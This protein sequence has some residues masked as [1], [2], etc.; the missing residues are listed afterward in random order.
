MANRSSQGFFRRPP[1]VP[2]LLVVASAGV[3]LVIWTIPNLGEFSRNVSQLPALWQ[4]SSN[5]PEIKRLV[6]SVFAPIIIALI[7]GACCWLWYTIKPFVWPEREEANR[8]SIIH[9]GATDISSR[10]VPPLQVLYQGASSIT[11][12]LPITPLPPVLEESAQKQQAVAGHEG[13]TEQ[14]GNGRANPAFS[15]PVL[16]SEPGRKPGGEGQEA[17]LPSGTAASTG[18]GAERPVYIT[19]NLLKEVHLSLHTPDRALTVPLPL[20]GTIIRVQLLAYIAWQQGKKVNRD[21]MLEDVFGHGKSDEEATPKRL[22]EAFDSHR[23]FLRKDLRDAIDRINEQAGQTVIPPGLDFFENGNKL[24][25]LADVCRVTD[26]EAVE[27][28][29]RMIE[30][31]DNSGILANSVPEEVN[32]ACLA[33]IDAYKGDFLGNLLKDYAEDFDPWSQSWV[34]RPYTLFRDYYLDALWYAA[35]YELK[36]GQAIEAGEAQQEEQRQHFD[37]AARFYRTYAMHAT[38]SRWD[39]KVSFGRNGRE[40]GERVMQSERAMRR[41]IMLYG[42]MDMTHMVDKVWTAYYKHMRRFSAEVWDADEDT[43]KDLE[44]AR[45]RTG[46]YRLPTQIAL[47]GAFPPSLE[48]AER[49]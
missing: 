6:A 21:K 12:T 9:P 19:I 42:A 2:T 16:R 29:F 28:S 3:S 33:L 39:L 47:P 48:P 10:P 13:E 23:K 4:V 24:W 30:Q 17:A 43:R 25:W 38:S 11:P 49:S 22:G 32:E 1:L 26:L 37:R 5:Q 14:P 15:A 7:V 40:H 36:K 18:D 41:C 35:G 20:S 31:A 46:A 34:R 45:S 27:A 44:A 8:Q